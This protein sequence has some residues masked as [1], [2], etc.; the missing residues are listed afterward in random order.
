MAYYN[1]TKILN[2][3][4]DKELVEFFR[5]SH[6]DTDAKLAA[7]DEMECRKIASKVLT[8]HYK[9][10]YNHWSQQKIDNNKI[11]FREISLKY[12]PH[13]IFFVSFI[14]FF[15]FLGSRYYSVD[16][17]LLPQLV[18]FLT[19]GVVLIFNSRIKIRKIQ[20][21]RKKVNENIDQII[22]KIKTHSHEP[23]R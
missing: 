6:L 21:K 1:W 11:T 17:F 18:I 5:N 7:L 20:E 19:I 15:Q 9:E 3:K 22:L 13:A 14:I 23:Q 16:N 4:S 12:S 10:L 2:T 8:S